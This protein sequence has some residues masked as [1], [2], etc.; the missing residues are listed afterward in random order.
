L[1]DIS[2]EDLIGWALAKICQKAE[3][4]FVGA[5]TG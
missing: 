4:E 2:G 3:N 5:H 1:L